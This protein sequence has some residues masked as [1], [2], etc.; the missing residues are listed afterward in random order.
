MNQ[1]FENIQ[2]PLQLGGSLCLDFVNTVQ[3]QDE[4]LV[5]ETF[6]TYNHF[7]AWSWKID[8]L[9][10]SETDR[11]YNLA[12]SQPNAASQSLAY[13]LWLRAT[14]TDLFYLLIADGTPGKYLHDLNTALEQLPGRRVQT[15][16]SG[17]QA[18]WA[19]NPDDLRRPLW[20]ILA[21]AEALLTSD[22]LSQVK[23]CP[24]C[25]WLFIDTSRN[26]MRRW[27]SMDIC[28]KQIKSR[29]QYQ[30]KLAEKSQN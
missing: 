11:L 24:N 3:Y 26:G 19:G 2:I 22:Q 13:I 1:S 18:S 16:A 20:P 7:L 9:S 14:I 27:C 8:L 10:T 4:S 17:Y 5:F 28:G 21:S 25:G 6:H 29:R 23:R 30:R 15:I 12:L